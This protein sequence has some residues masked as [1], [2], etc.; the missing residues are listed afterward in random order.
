MV[1]KENGLARKMLIW[2][3]FSDNT[4]KAERITSADIQYLPGNQISDT[5]C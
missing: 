1:V 3:L 4:N 2:T 5:Y